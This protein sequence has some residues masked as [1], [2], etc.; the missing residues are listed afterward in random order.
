MVEIIVKF[1]AKRILGKLALQ[2]TLVAYVFLASREFTKTR[3]SARE[4]SAPDPNHD[5]TFQLLPSGP[6]NRLFHQPPTRIYS[7]LS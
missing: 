4:F 3:R 6:V 1:R 5:Q 2:A 7:Q